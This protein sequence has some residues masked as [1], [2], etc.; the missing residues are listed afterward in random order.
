[1][2]LLRIFILRD[3]VHVRSMQAF[4]DANW[5]AM[6]QREK[7]LQVTVAEYRESRTVAQ[8]AKLHA[9]LQEIA[10]NAWVDGKQFDMETWKE[11]FRRRMIGSEETVLPDG[12]IIERG[13]STTTLDVVEFSTLIEKIQAY[14]A[15]D[16]GLELSM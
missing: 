2:S 8:N 11:F 12:E 15:T 16:L 7:P 3:Q 13:I 5:R 6:S 9:L 4:V 10:D 14:A 1:M